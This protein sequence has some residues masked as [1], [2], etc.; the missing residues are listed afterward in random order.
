[1]PMTGF[2]SYELHESEDIELE[3]NMSEVSRLLLLLGHDYFNTENYSIVK[4]LYKLLYKYND[5]TDPVKILLKINEEELYIIHKNF[6]PNAWGEDWKVFRMKLATAY[7]SFDKNVNE[8]EDLKGIILDFPIAPEYV[9]RVK[10]SY[11]SSLE[12]FHKEWKEKEDAGD[13]GSPDQ[14]TS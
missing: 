3:L 8:E 7:A 14:I 2:M 6:S 4:K 1:M 5:V 11:R 10:S 12:V 13:N 9:D